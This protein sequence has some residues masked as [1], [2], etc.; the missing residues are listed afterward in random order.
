MELLLPTWQGEARARA[1]DL[2]RAQGEGGRGCS[3]LTEFHPIVLT[4]VLMAAWDTAYK[5][6]SNEKAG[7]I[8]T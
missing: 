8:P 1:P 4:S 6:A 3:Q 7:H 2:S 5:I